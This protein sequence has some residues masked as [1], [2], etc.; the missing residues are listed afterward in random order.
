MADGMHVH[1]N[2]VDVLANQPTYD[3]HHEHLRSYL[4]LSSEFKPQVKWGNVEFAPYGSGENLVGMPGSNYS[5][6]RFV[7]AA[8]Y[9]THY[10][11]Q[12][13]ESANVTRLFRTLGSV[14]QFL[15]G[16]LMEDGKY[17]Y[18]IYTG[19]FSSATNTYYMSLYE[20]PAIKPYPMSAVDL[21]SSTLHT[22]A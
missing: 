5:P 3:W 22:F 17:E 7:R 15:G 14:E 6:D 20:D 18:T 8:Y 13:G 9:N 1:H 2:D 12:Q 21:D 19:G 4:N 11:A 16:G 10:P